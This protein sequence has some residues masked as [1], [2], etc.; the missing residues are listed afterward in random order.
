MTHQERIAA[1]VFFNF[2]GAGPFLRPFD[3]T[4][5]A[6]FSSRGPDADGSRGPDVIAAGFGLFGQG[7]SESCDI[8]PPSEFPGCDPDNDWVSV[9]NGT[10]FS[11]P[12]VTGTAAA[13][14]GSGAHH[15]R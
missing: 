12:L 5:T 1:D 11:T 6:G 9:G 13:L 7:L 14:R 3:G 4:Q 8:T 2:A 15:L 10:S